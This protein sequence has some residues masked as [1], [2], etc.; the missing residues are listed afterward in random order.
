MSKI[1]KNLPEKTIRKASSIV[2]PNK[3]KN[4]K[5]ATKIISDRIN[6]ERTPNTDIYDFAF[7][8]QG[9]F[10]KQDR[11]GRIQAIKIMFPR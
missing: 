3:I 10:L 7:E 8:E 11:N 9:Y 1:T 5:E 4:T 6:L 2:K